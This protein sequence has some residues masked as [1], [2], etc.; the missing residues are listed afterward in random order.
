M[1]K[2]A[3]P[4]L[5]TV[6]LGADERRNKW[7]WNKNSDYAAELMAQAE[8]AQDK[9]A[10]RRLRSLCP[11]AEDALREIQKTL[12]DHKKKHNSQLKSPQV[13]SLVDD[14][15]E[16]A[17]ECTRQ[18]EC[19]CPEGYF[20]TVDGLECLRI[21]RDK[22]TCQEAER[23]CENDYNA[24]LAIAKDPKRLSRLSD[25]LRQ[26]GHMNE[27]HWIGLSYNR[28]D[29]GLP[30]WQWSDGSRL[31]SGMSGKMGLDQYIDVKKS[32]SQ[33]RMVQFSD[34]KDLKLERVAI[35]GNY[36]GEYWKQQSCIPDNEGDEVPEYNY[37]C[38]FFMFKVDIAP[39]SNK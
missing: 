1:V 18:A 33:L 22:V 4:L 23:S 24:R 5:A 17:Y 37:I 16:I 36:Q 32:A 3:V 21:S 25:I 30:V 10:D 27:P 13:A 12:R 34:N 20:K 39:S 26:T 28:T 2:W 15:K 9:V 14:I 8:A 31:N 19:R 29:H 11:C 6:I 35:N 7:K 38:E